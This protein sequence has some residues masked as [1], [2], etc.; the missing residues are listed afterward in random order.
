LATVWSIIS[1]QL[2]QLK[3]LIASM[4]SDHDEYD[5][6]RY[7]RMELGLKGSMAFGPCVPRRRCVIT[8]ISEGGA[9]LHI[10]FLLDPPDR[11]GL[12]L[13]QADTFHR[14][15]GL[16]WRSQLE[17]GIKFIDT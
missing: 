10:G 4:F 11:F 8:D 14:E 1:G 13:L 12:S 15:C 3:Y 6:R 9:R 2:K 17:I 5:R 16:V 7:P